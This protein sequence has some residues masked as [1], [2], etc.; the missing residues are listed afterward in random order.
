MYSRGDVVKGPNPF[1][2]DPVR[3]YVALSND[4]HPFFRNETVYAAVT[5][6]PRSEA[7]PITGENFESGGLPVDPSYASPWTILT[8]KHGDILEQ[9]GV[10]SEE[11][12]RRIAGNAARYVDPDPNL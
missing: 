5:S 9:E 4:T 3:P 2:S 1:S 10:L 6:T 8:F 12:I 11:T 7:I